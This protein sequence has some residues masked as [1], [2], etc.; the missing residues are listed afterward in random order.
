MVKGVDLKSRE[1]GRCY[2]QMQRNQ[3]LEEKLLKCL[4]PVEKN[5]LRPHT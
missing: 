1:R 4:N 5:A 2:P 3:C